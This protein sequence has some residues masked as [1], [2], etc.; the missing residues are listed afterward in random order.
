MLLWP[1]PTS[2]RDEIERWFGRS[3]ARVIAHVEYGWLD[4]IRACDLYR[5]RMP[6]EAFE[7]LG[8]AGMW[9]SRDPVAPLEVTRVGD[10]FEALQGA[11][12]ELRIMDRLTPLQS[13]WEETTLHWSAIRMANAVDWEAAISPMPEGYRV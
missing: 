3:S 9:V 2:D 8:D 11:G 5:Y 10:L 12:V 6:A 4:R 1:L 7:D 13:L